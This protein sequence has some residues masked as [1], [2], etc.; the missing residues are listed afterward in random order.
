MQKYAKR[1]TWIRNL[2]Q[3]IK[4]LAALDPREVLERGYA[5]LAGKIAVGETLKIITSK[6]EIEAKINNIKERNVNE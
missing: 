4:L 1:V 6:Q 2:E 3:K 5:I